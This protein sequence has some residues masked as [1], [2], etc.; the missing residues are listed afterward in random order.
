MQSLEQTDRLKRLRRFIEFRVPTAS[1]SRPTNTLLIGLYGSPIVDARMDAFRS[2]IEYIRRNWDRYS[3]F[4]KN[5]STYLLSRYHGDKEAEFA[6]AVQCIC[7][8]DI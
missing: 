3:E 1:E 4:N 7:S 2:E 6:H 5:L 8:E